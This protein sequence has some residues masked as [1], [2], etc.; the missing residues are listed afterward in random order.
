MY[1][2]QILKLTFV[3]R[4]D[5]LELRGPFVA[6]D[7]YAIQQQDVKMCSPEGFERQRPPPSTCRLGLYRCTCAV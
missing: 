7:V 5:A 1:L 2:H 6:I 3:R 4:F